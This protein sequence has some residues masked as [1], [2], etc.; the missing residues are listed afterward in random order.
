MQGRKVAQFGNCRYDYSTDAAK[1]CNP[2]NNCDIPDYIRQTLLKGEP[3]CQQFTQCIINMYESSNIIPWHLDHEHFGPEVL[4]YT[5]GEERPLL[6]RRPLDDKNMI[7][8]HPRHCSKYL[9]S[10]QVRHVWEHSVPSGNGKRVSITFRSWVG[11][12]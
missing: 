9:L 3:N 10:G 2:P 4:V 11:P 7:D 1:R 8:A 6:L 12:E 5:F